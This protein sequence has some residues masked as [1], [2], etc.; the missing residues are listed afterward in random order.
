MPFQ[1][2]TAPCLSNGHCVKSY[3]IFRKGIILGKLFSVHITCVCSASKSGPI[4][5]FTMACSIDLF[6]YVLLLVLFMVFFGIPSV[7]KY[8]RKETIFLSSQK[9]TDGFKAP[10]ITITALSNTT[11]Y[12]WK[13][14]SN[15][16]SSMM[17]RYTNTFFRSILDLV[18]LNAK[19]TIE[20]IK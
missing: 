15:Q 4:M 16:T 14:K 13:T 17:G 20:N 18:I 12:G 2:F 19:Y 11:G 6:L 8:Q 3:V 9:L 1:Y 10:A 5:A 7:Q